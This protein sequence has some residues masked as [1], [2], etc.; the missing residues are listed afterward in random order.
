M[1]IFA[2]LMWLGVWFGLAIHW[3]ILIGGPLAYLGTSIYVGRRISGS[4]GFVAALALIAAP[5]LWYAAAHWNFAQL[6]SANKDF[7]YH[8]RMPSVDGVVV[9]GRHAYEAL[10]EDVRTEDGYLFFEQETLGQIFRHDPSGAH[11]RAN[12]FR[13]RHVF[14]ISEPRSINHA[15]LLSESTLQVRERE[16]GAVIAEGRDILLGG[17]ILYHLHL[18]RYGA[19]YLACGPG[20]STGGWRA[21]IAS[22]ASRTSRG[23]FAL[24]KIDWAAS[25]KSLFAGRDKEFVRTA[26]VPARFSAAPAPAFAPAR[27]CAAVSQSLTDLARAESPMPFAP[28]LWKLVSAIGTHGGYEEPALRFRGD[29]PVA[30]LDPPTAAKVKRRASDSEGAGDAD[31]PDVRGARYWVNVHYN[32]MRYQPGVGSST[33]RVMQGARGVLVK[34]A[35]L[36]NSSETPGT[37][38]LNCRRQRIADANGFVRVATS[39]PERLSSAMPSEFESGLSFDATVRGVT[40]ALSESPSYRVR[41]SYAIENLTIAPYLRPGDKVMRIVFTRR[42]AQLMERVFRFDDRATGYRLEHL[43]L[44]DVIERGGAVLVNASGVP[45]RFPAEMSRE[46]VAQHSDEINRLIAQAIKSK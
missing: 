24:T 40:D 1:E 18:Q 30:H 3:A 10:A 29:V 37:E 22:W 28:T 34:V 41:V 43:L 35:P 27:S 8:R 45:E 44:V 39:P 21:G 14:E 2:V 38:G 7:T 15:L 5:L 11:E 25:R 26:L 33:I 17:A 12:A 6:C 23:W 4:K 31:D 32:A 9:R 19:Q 36:D 46:D 20:I 42:D 16:S 13:G